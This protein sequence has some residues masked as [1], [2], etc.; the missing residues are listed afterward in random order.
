MPGDR[1][2]A[3]E[4]LAD[5]VTARPSCRVDIEQRLNLIG[6][7]PLVACADDLPAS[8]GGVHSGGHALLD[9]PAQRI[10]SS[11]VRQLPMGPPCWTAGAEGYRGWE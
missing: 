2:A 6:A 3:A 4:K 11:T 9:G 5:E 8:L 1:L 10:A 7:A